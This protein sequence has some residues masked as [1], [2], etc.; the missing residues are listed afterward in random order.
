MVS[1]GNSRIFRF[2]I[3]GYEVFLDFI[4]LF[5]KLVD[6]IAVIKAIAFIIE[7]ITQRKHLLSGFHST[8][9]AQVKRNKYQI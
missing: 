9:R 2:A 7:F 4:E 6:F 3:D 5:Q 8:V 1:C